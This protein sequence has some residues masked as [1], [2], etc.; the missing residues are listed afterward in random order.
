[1]ATWGFQSTAVGH[2]AQSGNR[3]YLM[4]RVVDY[5]GFSAAATD[6]VQALVIP[7]NSAVLL[8]GIEVLTADTAGNSGTVALGTFSGIASGGYVAAAAPTTVGQM[9]PVTVPAGGFV[10]EGTGGSDSID[11]TGATGTINA[12]LRVWAVVVDLSGLPSTM[13]IDPVSGTTVS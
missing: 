9:T 1:M 8:A 4:S 2:P 10:N 5:S 6:V 13:P 3:V 7:D 12:K 11:I